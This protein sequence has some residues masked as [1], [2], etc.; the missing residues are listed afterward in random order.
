MSPPRT[1]QANCAVEGIELEKGYKETYGISTSGTDLEVQLVM[2]G[3]VGSRLYLL[4]NE[5]TY[6]LFKLNN[7]EFTFDVDASLLPCGVNGAVYFVQMDGDGG[8]AR[9]PGN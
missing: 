6:Q 8:L 4:E 3:N 1:G 5:T 7:R 2:P 9:Y